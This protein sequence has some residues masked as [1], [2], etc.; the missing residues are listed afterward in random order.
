MKYEHQETTNFYEGLS[1][2]VM[3]RFHSNESMTSIF[4]K[5]LHREISLHGVD[6]LDGWKVTFTT[7]G[8]VGGEKEEGFSSCCQLSIDTHLTVCFYCL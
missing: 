6:D 1:F 3:Y 2:S 8:A 4:P 7:Y 5:T